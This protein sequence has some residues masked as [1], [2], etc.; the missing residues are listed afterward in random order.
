MKPH[1]VLLAVLLCFGGI[2]DGQDSLVRYSDVVFSSDFEKKTLD[3]YFLNRK[4]DFFQLF[5]ANGRL[6]NESAIKASNQK[7][8]S[9]LAEIQSQKFESRKNDR[10]V[11]ILYEDLHQTF[12]AKYEL[13]NRFEDIFNNGYYNCV[14]ASALYALA[15]QQLNIPFAIKEKPTHVY[16]IA[17][18]E[19]EQIMVETTTPV[20]GFVTIS[21]QF[22]QNFLSALKDQK[23]I[24]AKEYA[25]GNADALFDKYYFGEHENIDIK[26]L[27][28]IQYMNEGVY[29]LEKK[30]YEDALHAIEKAYLFYPSE[31]A[32]YLLMISAHDAFTHREPKDSIHA[33]C[34][35]KLSRYKK[36]GITQEMI[37]GEYA[38]VIQ[39][40]LFNKGEKEKL[41]KYHA[42]LLAGLANAELI[43]EVDF[44]YQYENGRFLYNQARFREAT[45]FFEKC[46]VLKPNHQEV[47]QIFISSIGQSLS[48]KSNVQ[49]LKSLED[50]SVRYPMLHQN[51]HF[52]ELLGNLYLEQF[53]THFSLGK[54]VEG[55]KYKTQFEN[56]LKQHNE[57]SFNLFLI[58][59]AY[60]SAAVYYFRKGQTS[61]AK[62]I[63][64]RGLEL[65]PDN[66]ELLTRKR[67]IE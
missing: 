15:F 62:S 11:K 13:E 32:G 38:R 35:A 43:K 41:S 28:G 63:I 58:G 66:Y 51:N 44:Q 46:L 26:K 48:N 5:M 56:F 31:R 1:L 36:Y 39:E 6:L 33:A 54:P 7:F 22:K 61:K 65:S 12:L 21:Q 4:S 42:V 60:S 34:L 14:S 19:N 37:Q 9:R 29:S 50:Y 30:N 25:S 24:S 67:M 40:L 49:V 45:P 52:N 8:Y 53:H 18:P 20:N 47:N 10:K 2:C 27:V 16:L 59:Q 3:D 64:A 17:Y 23:I 55:E 57:V